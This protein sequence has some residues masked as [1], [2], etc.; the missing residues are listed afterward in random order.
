MKF[1]GNGCCRYDFLTNREDPDPDLLM[2]PGADFVSYYNSLKVPKSEWSC[3]QSCEEDATCI[4]ADLRDNVCTKFY[5]A[6]ERFAVACAETQSEMCWRKVCG[7]RI[8]SQT[9]TTA[10]TTSTVQVTT[11]RTT[12]TTTT[13]VCADFSGKWIDDPTWYLPKDFVQTDCAGSFDD[14]IQ[15]TVQGN[16]IRMMSGGQALLGTLVVGEERDTINWSNAIVWK[17][18]KGTIPTAA[19]DAVESSAHQLRTVLPFILAGLVVHLT[20]RTFME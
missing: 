1:E 11:T 18:Y 8:E 16:S 15:Y 13:T 7:T 12:V 6:G 17:R 2:D 4:A 5:G 14:T 19:P 3:Q 20:R 10:T 9:T